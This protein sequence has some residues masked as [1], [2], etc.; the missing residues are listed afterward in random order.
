ME[1]C[2]D[3]N[4]VRKLSRPSHVADADAVQVRPQALPKAASVFVLVQQVN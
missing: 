1:V 4:E 2:T 3:E